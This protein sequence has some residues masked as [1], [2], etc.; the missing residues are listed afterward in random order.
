MTYN[1]ERVVSVYHLKEKIMLNKLQISD[2]LKLVASY[3]PPGAK[4]ADIGS[5]HA[6][7]PCYVCLHD[8][9]AKA[10]AGEINKGPFNSA[11]ET[12]HYYNLP[13]VVEVRLG[14]G[15]Q[16]INAKDQ[17]AQL[18]IAG[19]GGS[20]IKTILEEGKSKLNTVE[21]IITQPNM[22]ARNLRK[23]ISEMGFVITNEGIIEENG[24]IYEVI[25]ADRVGENPYSE[26]IKEKQLL[27]GP[28]LLNRKSQA[29][30]KKWQQEYKKL[31][32]VIQQMRKAK[33]QDIEKIEQFETELQWMWEVLQ[34]DQNAE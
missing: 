27:F 8:K 2:R 30:R 12:I 23:C 15:L 1:K 6:Y 24:K 21:R 9:T 7:L 18:V 11:S 26:E 14:N 17:V 3:L 34:S 5:D 29:F 13:H 31:Q 28:L 32:K 4:F 20:L 10:I 25:V 33:Q 22:D 16:V 19:M